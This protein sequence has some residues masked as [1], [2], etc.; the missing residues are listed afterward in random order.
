[1]SALDSAAH[2]GHDLACRA[3]SS[4][5]PECRHGKLFRSEKFVWLNQVR[6]DPEL[7][8]LAF[9][10]AYVLADLVNEREGYAWPGIAHLAA[11]C[12]VTEKGVKKVIRSLVERGHLS[13]EVGVGRGRTNRYRWI[14]KLE[15]AR[16]IGSASQARDDRGVPRQ[17]GEMHLRY[18]YPAKKGRLGYPLSTPKRGTVVLK[19]GNW[20]SR[21]GEPQFPQP[22]LMNLSMILL[23]DP[24][25]GNKHKSRPSASTTFGAYIRGRSDRGEAIRA[26]SRAIEN[27]PFEVI[28]LGANALRN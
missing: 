5:T 8:P 14:I 1:M 13:V 6:A 18:Q 15:D 27:A 20:R 3:I 12:H 10:L 25:P 26:F 28:V 21:K 7:T 22:Y 9:M 17:V 16:F 24:R 2:S 19:K 11:E 23:K 4:A